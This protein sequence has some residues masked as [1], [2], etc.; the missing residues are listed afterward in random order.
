MSQP[1]VHFWYDFSSPFAYLGS[2]QIEQVAERTGA[3]VVWRPML[4][5]ALFKQ[6][7]SPEVPLASMPPAKQRYVSQ[8]LKAWA[9]H[10]GVPLKWP[11]RFPTRSVTALRLALLAGDRIGPLSHVLFR[12]Y[13]VEDGDLT[14]EA[15]LERK[16]AQ[17]GLDGKHLLART[18]DG[19]VKERLASE[20]AEAAKA[21]VFGAP[22]CIV[23]RETG[24]YLFWGQDRLVLVE[25]ALAGW[26]PW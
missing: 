3:R 16:C 26:R 17:V 23:K 25:R 18:K 2:T 19:D 5:G 1:V 8:D 12:T 15:T 9:A 11:S 10:H 13:W 4:L 6:V 20:T 21:G 14:D 24:D 22:T 7:G